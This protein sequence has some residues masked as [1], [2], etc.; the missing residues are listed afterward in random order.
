M[1]DL[2]RKEL[3]AHGLEQWQ[4]SCG[5]NEKDACLHL[6]L[7]TRC[8]AARVIVF[9]NAITALQRLRSL[10]A[11]LEVPGVQA[12]QGGMQ[13]RARLK[14]LERFKANAGGRGCVLLATDVAAR[15]LDIEGVDVVIHYQLPRSA[16]VYVHRSGRTARGAGATGASIALIEPADVKGH[17]RLCRELERGEA[18]FPEVSISPKLLP[19][20]REAVSIA[21]QLDKAAHLE[22]RHK[23]G[24]SWRKR[25]AQEMDLDFSDEEDRGDADDDVAARRMAGKRKQQEEQLRASLKAL[26]ARLERPTSD[27][28]LHEIARSKVTWG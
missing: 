12:L 1:V 26:L 13:Q 14:A 27:V 19:R 15:G 21:R 4:L 8:A 17:R 11:L 28:P 25:L 6:L 23:A 16:E 10:L 22:S 2:S 9:V 24:V 5:A 7:R 20:V 3:V 18:G